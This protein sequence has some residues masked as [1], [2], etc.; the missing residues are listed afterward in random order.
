VSTLLAE[1]A[2]LRN[3][4]R[5]GFHLLASSTY[6][7]IVTHAAA[8]HLVIKIAK[9]GAG[10]TSRSSDSYG[11][12]EHLLDEVRALQTLCNRSAGFLDDRIPWTAPPFQLMVRGRSSRPSQRPY[13]AAAVAQQ[14]LPRRGATVY[15]G[16]GVFRTLHQLHSEHPR[17]DAMLAIASDLLRW[18]QLLSHSPVEDLQ[19]YFPPDAS[20]VLVI[21][22]E[23]V[24]ARVPSRHLHGVRGVRR[25]AG[26]ITPLS[27]HHWKV[28]SGGGH[29]GVKRRMRQAYVARLQQTQ[30]LTASI[31]ALLLHRRSTGLLEALGCSTSL[32]CDFG[33]S[34]VAPL[35]PIVQA[36]LKGS[37]EVADEALLMAKGIFGRQN[38]SAAKDDQALAGCGECSTVI[39]GLDQ[40]TD[41]SA[42][43]GPTDSKPL[44]CT[45]SGEAHHLRDEET[46]WC[47]G[48]ALRLVTWRGVGAPFELGD[49]AALDACEDEIIGRT[50]PKVTAGLRP[51]PGCACGHHRLRQCNASISCRARLG[52]LRRAYEERLLDTSG[53]AL[54]PTTWDGWLAR[55]YRPELV[56]PSIS[57]E[58]LDSREERGGG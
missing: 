38:G 9:E 43:L 35:P 3:I 41:G 52:T 28:W 14:R 15:A 56:A 25:P 7:D 34:L 50:A 54:L 40:P 53:S 36:A 47:L 58:G 8:P 19:L 48:V 23:E 27:H 17:G 57:V 5:G 42:M 2:A 6:K 1:F 30:V 45:H 18:A 44:R 39:T 22:P 46:L 49:R 29:G 33:C 4:S 26:V 16:A 11:Y 24:Y 51:G 13:R 10:L 37:S 55:W 20:G 32:S 21:D 12:N 31:V